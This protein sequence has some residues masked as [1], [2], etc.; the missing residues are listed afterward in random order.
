MDFASL[1]PPVE[2]RFCGGDKAPSSLQRASKF[3]VPTK[4]RSRNPEVAVLET[5]PP[6]ISK[7]PQ[8]F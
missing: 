8:M 4:T 1:T 7:P 6:R 2:D 5:S 3:F